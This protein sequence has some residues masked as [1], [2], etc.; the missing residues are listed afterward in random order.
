[1]AVM[2]LS[3]AAIVVAFAVCLSACERSPETETPVTA[4]ASPELV[5]PQSSLGAAD[6]SVGAEFRRR[7]D[8]YMA[9][10]KELGSTLTRLPDRSTPQQIDANQRALGALIAK[11]RP[12]A[13]PGH[14]FSTEM[15]TF[16]RGVL[17]RV[18]EGPGGGTLK[19]SIMD[20]NPP[21][22][23]IQVNGRYPDTVPLSTMPP[24]VLAALPPLPEDLEY[25]FVG[26][27]LILLDTK[28]HLIV[29]FV[30]DAFPR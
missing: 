8:D 20:E 18:L 16:V 2:R 23:A 19:A 6:A 28:A 29:D 25:R 27:R 4:G 12:D 30:D 17:R 10:Q 13:R 14:I 21:G 3:L 22:T 7:V 9:L 24:D 1:M 11:A 5:A 15:Q 26:H